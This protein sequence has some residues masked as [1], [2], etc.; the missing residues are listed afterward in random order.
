MTTRP[1]LHVETTWQLRI[2]ACT[3]DAQLIRRR[4]QCVEFARLL[5]AMSVLALGSHL[6]TNPDQALWWWLLGLSVAAFGAL[7]A[8]HHRLGEQWQHCRTLATLNEES[9]ARVRRDF[10]A[11]APCPEDVASHFGNQDR[12]LNLYGPSSLGQLVFNLSTSLGDSLLA[13]WLSRGSP[14]PLLSAHQQAVQELAPQLELRQRLYAHARSKQHTGGYR[15]EH[16]RDWAG[17]IGDALLVNH[18]ERLAGWSLITILCVCLLLVA[19]RFVPT[20]VVIAPLLLNLGFMGLRMR[21]YQQTFD[22]ADLQSDAL[23]SL[24]KIVDIIGDGEYRTPVLQQIGKSLLHSPQRPGRALR[25]L[26]AVV[27]HSRLRFNVIPYMMLQV[28]LLWDF[29]VALKLQRWQ[30]RYAAHVGDW[31][32]ATS[33]FEALSALANLGYENPH[34]RFPERIDGGGLQARQAIHPLLPAHKAVANDIILEPGQVTI[35]TGSNMSG[36]TTYMRTLGLNLKLAMA[37]APVACAQLRFPACEL[38]SAIGARDSLVQGVSYFMSEVVQ[39]QHVLE[40]VKHCQRQPVFLLDELLKGTNE[41]ERNLAIIGLLKE[42]CAQGGMGMMTTH[43]IALA[44]HP[45]LKALCRNIYFEEDID[46][47]QPEKMVF[48]YRLKEG[49]SMQTNA[50]K[51]LRLLGVNLDA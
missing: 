10:G 16:F 47:Q 11:L 18:R 19:G 48:S 1:D 15:L 31:L 22:R 29:H 27:H 42:L 28:V 13:E 24:A 25:E 38:Y 34:W 2:D 37:G 3:H 33:R 30:N 49:I 36:K 21:R 45:E 6:W 46:E 17:S 7:V 12:D 35:I 50:L 4:Q 9:L 41:H 8:W 44:T 5:V 32:D 39:I 51:L 23:Q 20:W 14:L 40:S 26:S 43:N